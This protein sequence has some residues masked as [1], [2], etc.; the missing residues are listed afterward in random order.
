MK[1][2]LIRWYVFMSSQIGIDIRRTIYFFFRLPW[3]I[4]DYYKFQKKNTTKLIFS[5]VLHD[6]LEES[7]STNS[8]Y[9]WQDLLV[10]RWIN[11]ANPRKHVDIGSRID[12]F[13]SHVASFRE[14]EVFD[15]RPINEKIPGVSFK[16]ADLMTS[17]FLSKINEEYCDSL[18]CLHALEH[19]GLGRY[20]DPIDNQGSE[21]G[22]ENMASLI[23]K[24]GCFYLSLPIGQER[25]EFN[26][27]RVFDPHYIIKIAAKNS[28]FLKSLTI[29][30]SS[31][32]VKE[33]TPNKKE[34]KKLSLDL[35]N[36]GIFIFIKG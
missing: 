1:R 8:E 16:Q 13:V 10:A 35:Y 11:K 25:V 29:V 2:I 12:G 6:K 26:A 21:K 7:G 24:D 36:L 20:G 32:F 14:I 18:S 15:I 33:I 30:N 4:L 28:L 3:F 34:L 23:Q 19:F 17:N 22:L 9:F 31:G 27:N 5:P